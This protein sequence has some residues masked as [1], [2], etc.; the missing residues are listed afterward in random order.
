[1]A[2]AFLGMTSWVCGASVSRSWEST[3]CQCRCGE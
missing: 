2:V 1:V 3:R